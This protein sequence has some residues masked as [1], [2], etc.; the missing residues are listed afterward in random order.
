M[1]HFFTTH[2]FMNFL[3]IVLYAQIFLHQNK[4]NFEFHP[5]DSLKSSWAN[6]PHE[7]LE[8]FTVCL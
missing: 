1:H 5:H 4:P 7:A 6:S 2:I 3:K 8:A